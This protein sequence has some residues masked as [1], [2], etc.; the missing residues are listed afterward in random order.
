M[1]FYSF[2]TTIP[3]SIAISVLLFPFY[4]NQFALS[5]SQVLPNWQQQSEVEGAEQTGNNLPSAVGKIERQ[6]EEDDNNNALIDTQQQ[7]ASNSSAPF[8]FPSQEQFFFPSVNATRQTDVAILNGSG[9]VENSRA[10]TKS[11]AELDALAP[12]MAFEIDH[13]IQSMI[14]IEK[15]IC[16]SM[17]Q[18]WKA[19]PLLLWSL[20]M[21]EDGP[22]EQLMILKVRLDV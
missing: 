8:I 20:Y 7:L 10:I 9:T 21:E 14:P 17:I 1:R 18:E 5:Q 2:Y 6:E 11:L 22:L 16:V 15:F 3:A 13:Y 4:T 19:N 12:K